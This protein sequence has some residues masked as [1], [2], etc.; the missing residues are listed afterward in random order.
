MIWKASRTARAGRPPSIAAWKA[1][2]QA[3]AASSVRP[4]MWALSASRS[5]SSSVESLRGVGRGQVAV[6]VAPGLSGDR[7]APRLE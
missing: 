3:R 4:T 2:S 1:R 5:R 6:G 7:L